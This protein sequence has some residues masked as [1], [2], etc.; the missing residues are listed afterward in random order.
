MNVSV[1]YSQ[2]WFVNGEVECFTGSHLYLGL[3][4]VVILL[5]SILLTISAAVIP[6]TQHRHT[7]QLAIGYSSLS[8][9]NDD[10]LRVSCSYHL[11]FSFSPH[12]RFLPESYFPFTSLSLSLSLYSLSPPLSLSRCSG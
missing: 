12:G 8:L 2:R 7:V 9:L 4:A 10:S 6:L 3:I 11:N 1:A 5:L